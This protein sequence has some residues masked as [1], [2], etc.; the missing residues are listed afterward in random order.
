M[1][2]LQ[3][4]IPWSKCFCKKRMQYGNHPVCEYSNVKSP[5]NR[6]ATAT[7]PFNLSSPDQIGTKLLHTLREGDTDTDPKAEEVKNRK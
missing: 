6:S 2:L 3:R 4:P 7:H 5:T 1:E